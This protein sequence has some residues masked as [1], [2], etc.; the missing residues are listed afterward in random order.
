[1]PAFGRGAILGF[2]ALVVMIQVYRPARDNPPIDATR[3]LE[4]AV[5]VPPAVEQILARSC[6]NCH[7]DQTHW[8]WYSNLA[9]ISWMIADHVTNGRRHLNF[10]EW[11]RPDV[12]DPA[13]YTRQKFISACREWRLGRM[14]LLS[15]ELLHPGAR[16]SSAQIQAFCDWNGS[17]NGGPGG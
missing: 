2:I 4:A 5:P 11:L 17:G 13:E 10:S 15:Y 1:M 8:P 9:P 3:T 6:N 12:D 16:L 14:P 7:S